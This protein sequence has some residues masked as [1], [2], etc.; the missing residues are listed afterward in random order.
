MPGA[1]RTNALRKC[2]CT[3][4]ETEGESEERESGRVKMPNIAF[5]EYL[6]KWR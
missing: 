1:H 2:S 3:S 6:F 5:T 4:E